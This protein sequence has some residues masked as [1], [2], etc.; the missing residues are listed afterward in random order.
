MSLNNCEFC[1][2]EFPPECGE[3]GCPNCHGEGLQENNEMKL[4][5]YI[6]ENHDGNQSSF[7]RKIKVT[8][9]R[10]GQMIAEGW[11]VLSVKEGRKMRDKLYAP[12]RTI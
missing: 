1:G 9:A 8:R 2:Y 11:M 6:A 12:K 7:A 3:C 4:V 10:V 5:D